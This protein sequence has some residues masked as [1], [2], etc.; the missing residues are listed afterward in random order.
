MAR[1]YN[2]L[3]KKLSIHKIDPLYQSIRHERNRTSSPVHV[4]C[5]PSGR[6]FPYLRS[7]SLWDCFILFLGKELNY[8]LQRYMEKYMVSFFYTKSPWGIILLICSSN[9][10]TSPWG[11]LFI[12]LC[13]LLFFYLPLQN[14]QYTWEWDYTI[15]K[16]IRLT[17]FTG[18]TKHLLLHFFYYLTQV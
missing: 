10:W 9:V 4:P 2:M 18:L 13:L 7:I 8:C 6:S 1:W 12:L 14:L 5:N 17:C 3:P 11:M 16:F 15:E